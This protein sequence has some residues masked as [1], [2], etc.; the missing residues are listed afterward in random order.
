MATSFSS[1][2]H[3][4]TRNKLIVLLLSDE[5]PEQEHRA[6]PHTAPLEIMEPL[7][8]PWVLLEMMSLLCSAALQAGGYMSAREEYRINQ[9]WL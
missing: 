9:T 3:L 7:A 8:P 2:S 5:V 1:S 6:G 4:Q